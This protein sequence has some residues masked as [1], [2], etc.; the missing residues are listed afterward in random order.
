MDYVIVES[1]LTSG[2]WVEAGL[3]SAAAASQHWPQ[4][5]RAWTPAH[6]RDTCD[7]CDGPEQSVTRVPPPQDTATCDEGHELCNEAEQ[8]LTSGV[9][10]GTR[11]AELCD[12][13]DTCQH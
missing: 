9:L 11:V 10:L 3:A 5:A 2:G 12:T 8:R 7:T 4:S 13:C 1:S 6:T